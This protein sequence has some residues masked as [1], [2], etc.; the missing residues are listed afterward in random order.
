MTMQRLRLLAGLPFMLVV[1][2]ASV[3]Y[4]FWI[5]GREAALGEYRWWRNL[6]VG[7]WKHGPGG[8]SAAKV[9]LYMDL[10]RRMLAARRGQPIYPDDVE[11]D[12]L[13]DLDMLWMGMTRTEV[14]EADR[15][16]RALLRGAP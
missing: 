14:A 12:L 9:A 16:V 5:H 10:T 11:D 7:S 8:A 6:V 2:L 13:E 4:E 15:Q 1:G 3:A